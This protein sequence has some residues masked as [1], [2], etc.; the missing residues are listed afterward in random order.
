VK[1]G[2]IADSPLLTTGFG[3]E[4]R[5]VAEALAQAGHDVVCFGLKGNVGDTVDDSPFRVWPVNPASPWNLLLREFFI[6]ERPEQIIILIDLFNLR[7]ILTYC[8]AA[9]WNGKT[10]IYLTPDGLPAYDE[11]IDLLRDVDHCVVTTRFCKQY[12]NS[13]GISVQLIAPPGVNQDLF[14]PLSNRDELRQVSGFAGHFVVGVFGR[15]CERKQQPRVLK[16]LSVLRDRET[17]VYLHC[18]RRGYWYLDQIAHELGVADQVLFAGLE[19]ELRGVKTALDTQFTT[20]I[21]SRQL[22][23]SMPVEY[24]YVERLNCCD[25]IVNCPHSGDVEH[26]IME[27]QSCGVPLAH[28]DDAGIM[29]EAVGDSAFLLKST[30]VGWGRIGERIFLVD[31]ESI[32]DAIMTVKQ[33]Q[34]LR[35]QLLQRGLNNAKRYPWS[36]L[37]NTMVELVQSK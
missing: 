14:K 22:A 9:A 7:E 24:G 2:V 32:A 30:D 28:T 37:R 33:D 35:E 18:Q 29:T 31:P 19:S 17:I 4:C 21:V 3:L 11:Y 10:I 13:K 20:D 27:S 26:I 16:A 23:C 6:E 8:R 36:C 1:L 25:L 34:V 15:N 12:L 5:E